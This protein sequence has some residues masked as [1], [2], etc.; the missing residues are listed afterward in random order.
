MKGEH[1][2]IQPQTKD[3][4]LSINIQDIQLPHIHFNDKD[5]NH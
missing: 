5:F 3:E 1:N 4:S 2:E